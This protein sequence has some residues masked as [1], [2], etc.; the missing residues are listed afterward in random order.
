VTRI[1]P[2]L[3][4]R[5]SLAA[6]VARKSVNAWVTEQL[7]QAVR[8]LGEYGNRRKPRSRPA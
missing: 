2:D 8:Q 5:I 3:H 6:T 4:R 7:E 1:N